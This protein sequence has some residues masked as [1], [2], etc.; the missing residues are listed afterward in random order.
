MAYRIQGIVRLDNSG[1]A[2]LGV[3]TA[4]EFDGKVSDKA[5]T[6]QT[7]G[8]ST[9][10]TGV[11]EL[12]LYDTNTGDLLRVTVDEFI[13]GAGIAPVGIVT[14]DT[15]VSVGASLIPDTNIAYDLG[16]TT[17]RFRDLYLEGNTIFLGETQLSADTVV[18]ST[19]GYIDAAGFAATTG[20]VT[21]ASFH[22]DGSSIDNIGVTGIGFGLEYNYSSNTNLPGTQSG[23][24]RLATTGFFQGLAI[25]EDDLRG[26]DQ[27]SFFEDIT[28]DKRYTIYMEYAGGTCFYS[29]LFYNFDSS[30]YTFFNGE[31]TGDL[32]ADGTPCKL[33]IINEVGRSIFTQDFRA[34]GISTVANLIVSGIATMSDHLI[35]DDS[36]GAGTEYALNVRTTGTSRF[37]VLG[38]GAILLGN[39]SAAPFIATNDHHATSKKYV[40]DAISSATFDNVELVGGPVWSSGTGSPEGV[41][42]APVGSLYS[43]TDGGADTTLYVKES[44]TGNTGWSAK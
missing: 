11:D 8:T 18:T 19:D 34:T 39:S 22:G 33:M 16:S 38:N 7:D 36:T 24:F 44:G 35:I 4:T 21:A 32:P 17:N 41:V 13:A 20:I 43:R 3:A 26:V 29:G 10:V 28:E 37:G 42:T 6:E 40:D 15:F 14:S 31:L 12:L 25:H 30:L 9:D 23:T 27:S 1:N 2:N 5:I